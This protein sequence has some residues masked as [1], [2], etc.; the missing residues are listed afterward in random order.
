MKTALIIVDH[1]SRRAA[2]NAQLEVAAETLRG[3]RPDLH[4]E[5][6][7]MELAEPNIDEAVRRCVAAGAAKVVVFPWFLSPGRHVT[8]DIPRLC[9][10][11]SEIHGV[12][13]EVT[14]PFGLHP[15]LFEAALSRAGLSAE[16]KP[17]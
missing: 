11:A 9:N 2:A 4:I 14:E 8:G 17:S 13:C 16:P 15:L 6:A 7:H 3:L 1:G 12:A 10:A 5:A